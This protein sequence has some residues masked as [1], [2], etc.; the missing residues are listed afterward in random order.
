MPAPFKQITLEQF[1][2]LLRSRALTRRLNAVHMHHTR[3]PRHADYRGHDTIVAM[4]RYHT[5]EKGWSDIAQHLTI[6]PGGELWLGRNWN[7]PPASAAGHN[8]N[9]RVGPFMFEM[10]GDFDAGQDPFTGAQ[11]DAALH[12]IARVQRRFGLPPESLHFHNQMSG[13]SC[14]GSAI[15]YREVLEALRQL[16]AELASGARS[17]DGEPGPFARDMQADDGDAGLDA[18]LTEAPRGAAEADAEDD[19]AHAYDEDDG[20]GGSRGPGGE[21]S[22][23]ELDALR[24][25]I[26]NLE[27]GFFSREGDAKTL[28]SDVDRIFEEDLPRAFE[29]ARARDE[30]LRL[31][32]Y[33]HGGLVSEA[34]GLEIARKHVAWWRAN[35]VYPIH[36]IWETGLFAS[37]GQV[38]RGGARGARALTRDLADYTTDP[39]LE[40]TAR[41]FGGR[42]IWDAMKTSARNASHPGGESVEA[43]G[44][45]YVAQKLKAFCD[46]HEGVELHAVGHSAGSIFHAHFLPAAL[47][48]GV[49]AFKSLHFLAPAIRSDEFKSRLMGRVGPGQGVEHLSLFTMRRDLERD[50]HCAYVYRKSL[51]YLIHHALERERRAPILG[52]EESL[53]ADPKLLA[54]FRTR[55]VA[56]VVWSTTDL[57]TGRSAS[58][59]REHGGFDDDPLTMNSVARRVLDRADADPL[60]QDYPRS[61]GA[62]LGSW[63]DD[64]DWLAP[65]WDGAAGGGQLAAAPPP[66][67]G[68]PLAC[69]PTPTGPA[70]TGSVGAGSNWN[71]APAVSGRRLALCVGIDEYRDSPLYGCVAD[72]R[73]WADTLVALGFAPPLTL[74]NGQ[75]TRAAILAQ[76]EG[77]ITAARP[78]DVLVFQ[79]AGHGTHLPDLDGDEQNGHDEALCP[80]DMDAGAF[81]IDDDIRALFDRLPEGVN[82]TCFLDCCHSGTGTRFAVGAP[83]LASAAGERARFLPATAARAE[84]HRRFR[85]SAAA[86]P[87]G[88]SRGAASWRAAMGTR[89]GGRETM[90]NVA[91]AACLDTEVALESNGQGEFTLRATRVLREAGALTLR[92]FQH[93]VTAAFGPAPRQHP[94]LDCPAGRETSLLLQPW[95]ASGAGRDRAESLAARVQ[96]LEATCAELRGL[97]AGRG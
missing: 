33:A 18:W 57:A 66:A 73:L 81:L 95:T 14:P 38:L 35:R 76:L 64:A 31:L 23:G 90:R 50:D 5:R 56:E 92:E 9:T 45:H 39:A 34:K 3:R 59:A 2:A 32:F 6:G 80:F 70:W 36:F 60:H 71:G 44:A 29:E 53:R 24:P 7:R 58:Q 22:R 1:D 4:W 78:G 87:G 15:D 77:L 48:L 88:A 49:P 89:S 51:L 8:G 69:P 30:P 55:G 91:F 16:H 63:A 62:N 17:A 72:M 46:R 65:G 19:H 94:Q 10:V 26:V 12:V 68:S 84:A 93:R 42:H 75:A 11:R 27:A 85:Q 20:L 79:Y 25:H 43:G 96:A 40:T 97:L 86:A 47:A 13:K 28:P 67:Y 41:L 82:L 83:V 52:L 74:A 21:L 61:R 37:I 54:L